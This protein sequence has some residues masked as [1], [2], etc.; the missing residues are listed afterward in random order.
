MVCVCVCVSCIWAD[1]S[2]VSLQM[3]VRQFSCLPTDAPHKVTAVTWHFN[4]TKLEW[5]SEISNDLL[6]SHS[7][8]AFRGIKGSSW[9]VGH[10][11]IN[12]NLVTEAHTAKISLPEVAVFFFLE[13]FTAFLFTLVCILTSV[14]LVSLCKYLFKIV[15]GTIFFF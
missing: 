15:K 4:Y 7:G 10:T 11:T 2:A 3:H 13:I 6:C 9:A 12:P 5:V 14:S 8:T 1:Q